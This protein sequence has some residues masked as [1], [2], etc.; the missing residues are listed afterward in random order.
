MTGIDGRHAS[1]RTGIPV[2]FATVGL[3]L[4]A[5]CGGGSGSGERSGGGSSAPASAVAYSACVRAH[6]VPNFP[7]P[8]SGGQVPK[9]D[10]QQLGVSSSRLQ[11]AQQACAGLMPIPAGSTDEQQQELLCGTGTC[12]PAVVQRW[13]NGLETLA[14]CLRAHGE[15]RWPDPIIT[16]LRGHPPVPHFPY[17]QGGIDHHSPQVLAKV[18]AC[19]RLTGFQGLPLP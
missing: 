2:A 9:A 19:V 8:G 4:A 13:M 14:I 5:A 6:G 15:P 11:S 1:Y 7:D 17:E 10:A 16:S 12:S 3:L 18:Q